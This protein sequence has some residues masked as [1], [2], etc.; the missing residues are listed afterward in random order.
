MHMQQRAFIT[1]STGLVGG[2]LLVQLYLKG[3]RIKALIRPKASFEQLRLISDFYNVPF[4]ELHRAV[5]WVYGDTLDYVN[6]KET[7]PGTDVVYHCAGL[8][9]FGK[10][11]RDSLLRTNVQ[12]TANMVDA[13]LLAGVKHFNYISSIAALGKE[14]DTGLIDEETSRDMSKPVSAYSESKFFAELEVWRGAAEGLPVSI[15]N[16]GVILGPGLPDRGSLLIF[17]VAAKGIPVYTDSQTGYVDVRDVARAA[18]TLVEKKQTG[19]R[20]VMVAENCHNKTLFTLIAEAFG[21]K[22]PRI[23]AGMGLLR[24]AVGVSAL[25]SWFTGKPSQLTGETL[26]SIAHPEQY[27]SQRIIDDLGFA[28]TPLEETIHD[29]A[30]FVK[31]LLAEK[32]KTR[33]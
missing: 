25:V 11:N 24:V 32:Q 5:N 7:L 12:G 21:K 23:R 17:N 30:L 33:S 10:G 29:T 14:S 28:F 26:R 22:P 31:H 20:Y 8:V 16:P 15:L 6:L 3:D 27:T 13:A 4:Q 1:G 19:K 2:H 18:I 9:S